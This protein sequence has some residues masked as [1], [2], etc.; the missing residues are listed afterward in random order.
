MDACSTSCLQSICPS[1][2]SELL[3][4]LGWSNHRITSVPGRATYNEG[5]ACSILFMCQVA[6]IFPCP[7]SI[8]TATPSVLSVDVWR[9]G[10]HACPLFLGEGILYGNGSWV[11]LKKQ[12]MGNTTRE[13]KSLNGHELGMFG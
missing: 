10:K 13:G 8:E 11:G 4:Y 9:Q 3:V 5:K 12:E 2:H 7:S 1:E 6:S